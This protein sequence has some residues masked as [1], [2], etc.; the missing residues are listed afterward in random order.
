M[1]YKVQVIGKRNQALAY[2]IGHDLGK[3]C[4][5]EVIDTPEQ[6]STDADICLASGV[7]YI[8]S[9]VHFTRPRLGVWGFHESALPRGRGNSPIQWSVLKGEKMLTVYT[10]IPETGWGFISK[11]DMHELNAPIREMTR[12]FIIIILIASLAIYLMAVFLSRSISSPIIEMSHLSKKIQE[13]DFS[14]RNKIVSSDEIGILAGAFNSMTESIE[15]RLRIKEGVRDI[16]QA[17]SSRRDLED[18]GQSVLLKLISL[19]NSNMAALYVLNNELQVFE[20]F[21]SYGAHEEIRTS[22]DKNEFEGEFGRVL[23]SGEICHMVNIPDD[24]KFRFIT[25]AGEAIPKEIITIPLK[26]KNK[27]IAIISLASIYKYTDEAVEILNQSWNSIC[28]SY[29][30]LLSFVE[31]KRL[32]R[33]LLEMNQELEVQAEELQAQSE[34]LKSQSEELQEQNMELDMQK[35]QVEEANRLKSEFISNM[36]HELRTPL[37]SILALSRVLSMRAKNKLDEEELNYLEIVERNGK[38]L[39]A[40]INDILDLSKIEAGKMDVDCKKISLRLLLEG[41]ID[42]LEPIAMKKGVSISLDIPDTLPG[43]ETD[44]LKLHQIFL[45]VIG[46]AVKFTEKGKVEITASHDTELVKIKVSDSGIGIPEKSLKTIFEEFR[47]V[48]GSSSRQ[49]EG[50]GLGLSI[51]KKMIHILDGS[52][53]VESKL[54]KGSVFTVSIPFRC[55]KELLN[56]DPSFKEDSDAY[57]IS[58]A[59]YDKFLSGAGNIRILLVEDTEASVIQVKLLLEN[60]GF[61]I[62]VASGGKEAIEYLRNNIP[63]GIIL[64]LMMPEVDGF[65]VL[66]HIRRLDTHKDIPVLILTAKDL[67]IKEISN[68]KSNNVYQIIQKG[69]VDRKDLLAIINKILGLTAKVTSPKPTLLGSQRIKKSVSGSKKSNLPGILVVDNNEDNMISINAILKDK[70]RLWNAIEG[71]EGIKLAQEHL[72]DL[73]LLDMSLPKMDGVEVVRKLKKQPDTKNIPV[74]S[75][76]ARAMEKDIESFLKAGCNDFVSKPV[77]GEELIQKIEKLIS[78]LPAFRFTFK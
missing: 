15:S 39:L 13:G 48:D 49:Y 54:G 43:I 47:Q 41:I 3:Y 40:L 55:N 58:Q 8:M 12:N 14:V 18:F 33:E 42:S 73:I 2:Y 19:T 69:D 5:V 36:S 62:D 20:H 63:D 32:S 24:T 65:E 1:K 77:D 22:F 16:S 67:S 46:N 9:H 28:T 27:V 11:Q 71:V 10:Y 35:K 37:N 17:C 57:T 74:I 23:S 56:S 4:D 59:A 30:H 44:E 72:P 25:V 45:N 70:Y 51:V 7:Y 29:S 6:I 68:L 26:E 38:Q 78:I 60:E 31:T 66:S 76:S 21:T 50:T 52:I 53:H 64:D 34:E 75:V 61:T